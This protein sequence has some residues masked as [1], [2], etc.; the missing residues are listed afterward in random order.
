M[1]KNIIKS[2]KL[3][4]SIIEKYVLSGKDKELLDTIFEEFKTY[5]EV[6]TY[7]EN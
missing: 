5:W 3:K 7:W 6:K 2:L 4:N 1:T